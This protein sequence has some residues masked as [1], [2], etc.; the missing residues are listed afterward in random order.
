MKETSFKVKA[1]I[2]SRPSSLNLHSFFTLTFLSLKYINFFKKS[3]AIWNSKSEELNSEIPETVSYYSQIEM[4]IWE[5]RIQ[6]LFF[7][8]PFWDDFVKKG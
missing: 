3:L 7:F 8:S 5:I 1:L 2:D 6:F 4:R